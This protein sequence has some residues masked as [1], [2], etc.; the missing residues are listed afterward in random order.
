MQNV[1]PDSARII[2]MFQQHGDR[3][4]VLHCSRPSAEAYIVALQA[5]FR[6]NRSMA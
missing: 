4:V 1:P 5:F 2:A 3:M 6:R